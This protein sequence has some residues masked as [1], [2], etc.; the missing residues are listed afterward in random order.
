MRADDNSAFGQNFNRVYYPK[1]SA[2]W[3]VS[4]EPFWTFPAFNA[5][6]LRAA[7]GESGKQP[8]TYSAIPTYA[9]ATG[10]GDVPTLTPQFLGNPD[11]GPERSREIE[12][13]FDLGALDDR[14]GVELSHYRKKTIDAILDRQLAP[15][16]GKPN[17]QPF[18]AGEIRNWG[19]ELMVRGTPVLRD[20]LAWDVTVGLAH[21]DSEVESSERLKTCSTSAASVRVRGTS[22]NE[23]SSSAPRR[24]RR[25]ACSPSST[26]GNTRS[27]RTSSKTC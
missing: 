21:N 8:I 6:K 20:N 7:Y 2:S 22:R 15:S 25:A 18:N 10:P 5:L 11:L 26:G 9:T 14:I 4:E 16:V 19:T 3:V 24:F 12:V 1:F 13:G 27:A 23:Q 17:T